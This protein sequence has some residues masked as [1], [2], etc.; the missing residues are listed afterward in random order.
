MPKVLEPTGIETGRGDWAEFEP[1]LAAAAHL[2]PVV[3]ERL[4]AA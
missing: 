1:F 4:L 2:D 3:I